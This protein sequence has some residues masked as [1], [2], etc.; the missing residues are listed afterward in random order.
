MTQLH[1]DI[2]HGDP[3][4]ETIFTFDDPRSALKKLSDVFDTAAKTLEEYMSIPGLSSSDPAGDHERIKAYDRLSNNTY[5][6]SIRERELEWWEVE[7]FSNIKLLP[8]KGTKIW[9]CQ[10]SECNVDHS[11]GLFYRYDPYLI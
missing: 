10:N 1:L 7:Q 8:T 11:T 5:N 2:N 4:A 3:H 9:Q 6:M